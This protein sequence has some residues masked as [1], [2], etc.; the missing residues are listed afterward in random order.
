MKEEKISSD[1]DCIYRQRLSFPVQGNLSFRT[2]CHHQLSSGRF[3]LILADCLLRQSLRELPGQ[4]FYTV[5]RNL[6]VFRKKDADLCHIV[7]FGPSRRRILI[8]QRIL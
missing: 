3:L 6:L 7:I 8:R 4:F 1:T 2:V 5:F